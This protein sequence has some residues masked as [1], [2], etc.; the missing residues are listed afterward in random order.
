MNKNILSSQLDAVSTSRGMVQKGELI[1]L[2]GHIVGMHENK[3]LLSLKKEVENDVSNVNHTIISLG[4]A[5]L[6]L[7]LYFILFLY[8]FYHDKKILNSFKANTFIALQMLL[9]I[10]S[11]LIIFKYTDISINII[12][13]ALIPLLIYTFYKFNVSFIV[14]LVSIIIAGFFAPNSFEFIFIQTITGLVAMFSLRNT[15]KRSQIFISAIYVF[16]TYIVLHSGFF[17][18]KQGDFSNLLSNDIYI[19]GI[20]SALLVLYLPIVYLYEKIFGFLSDFTLMEL[21]DTN[22]PALC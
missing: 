15:R 2:K 5:L 12:P 14:F 8:L 20:S 13:F 3:V 21:C 10:V 6:F 7:S 18:M 16:I 1:I 17:L 4:I 22:N 11:V 19:Y 9:L